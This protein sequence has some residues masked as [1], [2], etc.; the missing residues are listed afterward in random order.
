VA[1]LSFSSWSID[2]QPFSLH[3]PSILGR[4]ARSGLVYAP[5]TEDAILGVCLYPVGRCRT[6]ISMTSSEFAANMCNSHMRDYRAGSN[7]ETLLMVLDGF[8]SRVDPNYSVSACVWA[9]NKHANCTALCD[10]DHHF[11]DLGG[12]GPGFLR[13][14]RTDQ[15][16][17]V[18]SSAFLL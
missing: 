7:S 1:R 11:Q 9:S 8:L 18:V 6:A 12:R 4:Y 5:S 16:T 17:F 13:M 14:L 10:S 2:G 15:Y 3:F